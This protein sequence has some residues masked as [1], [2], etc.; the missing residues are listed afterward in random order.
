[1]ECWGGITLL[2]CW[3]ARLGG[4]TANSGS[5]PRLSSVISMAARFIRPAGPT[6][7]EEKVHTGADLKLLLMHQSSHPYP[8][9]HPCTR[10]SSWKKLHE[11]YNKLVEDLR[12]REVGR[13]GPGG[14]PRGPAGYPDRPDRPERRERERDRGD[15]RDS[16]SVCGLNTAVC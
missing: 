16:R 2:F 7:V 3:E 15:P 9:S 4:T 13:L 10:C 8:R 12:K 6:P 5:P 1:M 14:P 11:V